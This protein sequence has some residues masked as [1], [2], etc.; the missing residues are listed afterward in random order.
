MELGA[1]LYIKRV[2]TKDNLADDPSRERY[3]LLRH[4]GVSMLCR[5]RVSRSVCALT[6]KAKSVEAVLDERFADAQSWYS[7]GV[8]AHKAWLEQRD[9]VT[10]VI[11]DPV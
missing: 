5:M 7:L 9:R 3:G 11:D 6:L 10:T 2:P 8:T 4:M 1:A